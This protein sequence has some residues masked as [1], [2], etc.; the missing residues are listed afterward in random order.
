MQYRDDPIL[1]RGSNKTAGRPQLRGSEGSVK[2]FNIGQPSVLIA[3]AL[4]RVFR[5]LNFSNEMFQLFV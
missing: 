3:S 2:S 5:N 1:L 4:F